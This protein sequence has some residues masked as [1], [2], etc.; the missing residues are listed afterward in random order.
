MTKFEKALDKLRKKFGAKVVDA[1]MEES[2]DDEGESATVD[3]NMMD[4]LVK[5]VKDLQVA[6]KRVEGF[7]E[8]Q[9]AKD[10][11]KDDKKAKDDDEEESMDDDEGEKSENETEAKILE[12]VTALEAA[13]AKLLKSKSGD[14]EESEESE[15]DDEE[16][17]EDDMDESE[18]DDDES[19]ESED[20]EG[21]E[22]EES[23]KK[24]GKTGDA[25]RIEILAPGY[26][27][28]K[29]KDGKS[30]ALKRAYATKDGKKVIDSLT[31][32]KEPNYKD[33]A[34]VAM[35][36]SASSE[37]LKH[38]RGNGLQGTRGVGVKAI[39]EVGDSKTEPM[40]AE[41]LNELNAKFYGEKK[42]S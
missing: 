19:E 9:K 38:Q 33:A 40:T 12:R 7:L 13:V 24:A 5:T 26:K 8:N 3:K 30:G 17:S 15:D 18:D 10:E 2:K 21:E 34:Q 32:G 36:F 29:G 28:A 11:D 39:A 20:E 4:E 14:E 41:Q 27:P 37:I 25:A 35:L 16:E 1:A 31:G 42:E 23:Q 22:G 6:S